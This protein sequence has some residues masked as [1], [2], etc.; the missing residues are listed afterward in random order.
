MFE[1]WERTD[2]SSR[3]HGLVAIGADVGAACGGGD[4]RAAAEG[5][6]RSGSALAA[7]ESAAIQMAGDWMLA[8]LRRPAH[9]RIRA[10]ARSERCFHARECD[11]PRIAAGA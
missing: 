3:L 9:A 6:G 8:R 5:S 11:S 1:N 2:P 10:S 4:P 7:G